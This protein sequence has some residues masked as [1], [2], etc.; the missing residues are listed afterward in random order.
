MK[1]LANPTLTE[2]EQEQVLTELNPYFESLK[3]NFGYQ[4]RD[5]VILYPELPNLDNLLAKFQ[6]C[7]THAD[8]EVRYIIEGEGVFGFVLPDGSLIE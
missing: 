2:E 1:K 8:D 3:Q 6:S 4:D 5:L 7:H